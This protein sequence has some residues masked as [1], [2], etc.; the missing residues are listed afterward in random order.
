MLADDRVIWAP[1]ETPWGTGQVATQCGHLVAVELPQLPVAMAGTAAE[2]WLGKVAGPALQTR[3]SAD[4]TLPP[5]QPSTGVAAGAPGGW[6]AALEAY[7]RGERLSWVETD[8]SWEKLGLGGF[9]R[10]V[11][12]AL[13]SIPAG[14]TVSY[15]ELAEKAGYPRAAR[16]VGNAMAANPVPVVIPCHRVVRGDGSLGNYGNDRRWKPLLLRHEARYTTEGHDD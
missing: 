4:E 9:K 10:R 8:I 6:T 5:T 3:P 7:F 16:A 11:Y 12:S 15:G 1:F 13:L 14:E 2:I